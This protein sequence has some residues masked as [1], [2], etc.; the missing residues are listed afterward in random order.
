MLAGVRIIELEA[1]GPAPFASMLL[2][3]LGADVIVVHKPSQSATPGI[4]GRLLIV[5]NAQSRLISKINKTSIR[6]KIWSAAQ[7][8]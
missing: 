4:P 5:V 7:M 3:D 2:A 1:L 6:L 8:P